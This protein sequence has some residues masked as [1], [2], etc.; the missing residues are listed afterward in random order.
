MMNNGIM[1]KVAFSPD[2]NID[3]TTIEDVP[4]RLKHL[5]PAGSDLDV[6]Q[7]LSFPWRRLVDKLQNG[8]KHVEMQRASDSAQNE[9]KKLQEGAEKMP[10]I[11][12]TSTICLY[13]L[14]L[15]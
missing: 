9:Q 10:S 6:A 11:T 3:L 1:N 4:L 5:M 2:N 15:G 8:F 7:S 12:R 14:D 13:D